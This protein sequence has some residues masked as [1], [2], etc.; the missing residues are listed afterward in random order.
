MPK[1]PTRDIMTYYEEQ[2]SGEPL[3]MIMGLG[4]D[5][6]AWL[7][8][9]PVL[10]RH[11]RVITYDNRGAGRSSSPDKPYS[12]AGMANDAAALL[13]ALGIEKAHVLGFSMGGYIAQELALQHPRKVEKLILLSTAASIEGY[14]RRIVH[15]MVAVRRT[16]L[17]REGW[18]RYQ[19]PY[20]YSPELL[21]DDVRAEEAIRANLANEWPQ[22]DHAFIRQCDAILAWDAKDRVAGIKNQALVAVGG[23]DVLVPPRNSERLAKKLPNATLKTLPGAHVGV[24]ENPKEYVET[25]LAFLGGGG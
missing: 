14:I 12:I 13:D 23:D 3:L 7:R 8:V 22:G 17:S 10:A 6:Q 19:A 5:L 2:G 25:F 1:I 20:L 9:A 11:Y 15:G 18:V 21:D 4:G 16:N 24:L